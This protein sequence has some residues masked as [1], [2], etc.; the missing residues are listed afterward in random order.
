MLSRLFFLLV[1]VF[2]VTMNVL[3]WRS[4]FER[5]GEGGAAVPV[6]RVWQKILTAPDDSSLEIRYKDARIGHCR[7]M[8]NVGEA[9]AT[10]KTMNEDFEPEGRVQAL[11]GYTLD[12]EGHFYLEAADSRLRFNVHAE[13]STNHHWQAVSAR[14]GFRPVWWELGA[15]NGT[16]QIEVRGEDETERWARTLRWGDLLDP[17]KLG[18]GEFGGP[19]LMALL[20]GGLPRGLLSGASK[21]LASRAEAR[22]DWLQWGR[23]KVRVYRVTIPL[24]DRPSVTAYISRVGEVLRLELPNRVLLVNEALQF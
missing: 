11:A 23:S 17:S 5:S 9:E 8:A 12:L 19:V 2:W 4:E 14:A 24:F 16:G 13:F 1:T 10:G 22:N 6:A 7:W 3:L 21:D 15:T 20:S 18:G